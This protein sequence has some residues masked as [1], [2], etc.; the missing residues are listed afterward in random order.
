MTTWKR[1]KFE[2]HTKCIY[3]T[4]KEFKE[5][6]DTKMKYFGFKVPPAELAAWKRAADADRRS[7]ASWLRIVAAKA[8]EVYQP[9]VPEQIHEE[10]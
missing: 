8:A 10:L 9:K 2:W 5:M 7:I 6:D 3:N 4:R 1:S